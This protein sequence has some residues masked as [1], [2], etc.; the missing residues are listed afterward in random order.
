LALTIVAVLGT[1]IKNLMFAIMV[2]RTPGMT[3]VVRSAILTVVDMEYIEAARAGGTRDP[4]IILKHII[5]NSIGPIM[6]QTTMSI[7]SII[8]QAAAL[9]FLGLGIAP[10][11]PE[12][13][14]LVSDARTYLRTNTYLLIF[15]GTFI[16]MAAMSLN[17]IGD[18]LRDALDPRLKT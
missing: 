10:P 12:W 8:L 9:S 6:V 7:A 15:P 1:D 18:G 4:R 14:A 5:P 16:V 2:A 17:L 11:T 3:R 13:G